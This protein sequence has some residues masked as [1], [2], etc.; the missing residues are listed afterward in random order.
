MYVP[1]AF[2]DRS[3]RNACSVKLKLK[4]WSVWNTRMCVVWFSN[5]FLLLNIT[6]T[7]VYISHWFLSRDYAIL[8]SMHTFTPMADDFHVIET[9][10]S[11]AISTCLHMPTTGNQLGIKVYAMCVLLSL[12]KFLLANTCINGYCKLAHFHLMNIVRMIVE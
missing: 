2:I 4:T 11:F 5:I 3:E 1:S 10:I 8:H 12:E 9:N 6:N 7:N